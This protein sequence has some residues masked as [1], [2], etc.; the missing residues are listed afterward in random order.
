MLWFIQFILLSIL[1]NPSTEPIN[2]ITALHQANRIVARTTEEIKVRTNI[3]NALQYSS[4]FQKPV[5]L[6]VV[7]RGIEINGDDTIVTVSIPFN[8]RPLAYYKTTHERRHI[9]H[10]AESLEDYRLRS[11][12]HQRSRH[13]KR[14][15][16]YHRSLRNRRIGE[17]KQRAA[18]RDANLRINE[19]AQARKNKAETII[20]KFL[21]RN[22]SDKQLTQMIGQSRINIVVDIKMVRIGQVC[23]KINPA[24]EVRFIRGVGVQILDAK[25]RL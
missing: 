23:A 17:Q 9:R 10:L 21:F 16:S 3:E 24:F 4:L 25:S 13:K 15:S 18:L 12:E 7:V 2:G 5:K 1:L 14:G 19:L 22:L 6:S 11:R 8:V 20:G